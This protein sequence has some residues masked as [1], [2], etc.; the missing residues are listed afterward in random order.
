MND[1]TFD[2]KWRGMCWSVDYWKGEIEMANVEGY[3]YTKEHILDFKEKLKKA[4]KSKD[5]FRY[6]HAERFI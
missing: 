5:E 2:V 3:G 4:E 1:K 6:K